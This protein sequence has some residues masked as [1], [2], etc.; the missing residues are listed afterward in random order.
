MPEMPILSTSISAK[1][2]F[3]KK[4]PKIWTKASRNYVYLIMEAQSMYW[5]LMALKT[6]N[7]GVIYIS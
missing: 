5:V 6:H 2:V 1:K 4:Y 7:I 3:G